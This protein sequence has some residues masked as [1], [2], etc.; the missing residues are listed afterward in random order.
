M[1]KI[2][3]GHEPRFMPDGTTIRLEKKDGRWY[4]TCE[5]RRPGAP[6]A[7]NISV[8]GES[9]G[10]MGLGGKLCRRWLRTSG[11]ELQGQKD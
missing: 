8:N 2:K 11:V 10:L 7:K 1:P 6:G 5:G 3:K 4:G 9:N